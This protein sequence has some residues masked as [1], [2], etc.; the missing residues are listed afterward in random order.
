MAAPPAA[1]QGLADAGAE[2]Q[3]RGLGAGQDRGRGQP[4]ATLATLDCDL[5]P[6]RESHSF[7]FL[8]G[9]F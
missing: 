6:G 2:L 5:F 4:R 9:D 7:I 8:Y 1:R 3:R